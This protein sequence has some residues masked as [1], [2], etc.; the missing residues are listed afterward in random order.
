[1]TKR[2]ARALLYQRA[3][4]FMKEGIYHRARELYQNLLDSPQPLPPAVQ[5]GIERRIRQI[6]R[7]MS[8]DF[9]TV[10]K[11]HPQSP[12]PQGDGGRSNRNRQNLPQHI[13]KGSIE[14]KTTESFRCIIDRCPEEPDLLRICAGRLASDHRVSEAVEAYVKAAALFF[15]RGMIFK[16]WL[17]NLLEWRLQKAPVERLK[18]AE[19]SI[20]NTNPRSGV[21]AFVKQLS[22]DER[23]AVFSRFRLISLPAG[24]S[25]I[26]AGIGQQD[27]YIVVSG[28]LKAEGAQQRPESAKPRILYETDLFGFSG[29]DEQPSGLHPGVM[30]VT[31]VELVKISGDR[32][33]NTFRRHPNA[34]K[35]F[36]LLCHP[37]GGQR[38]LAPGMARKGE[39]YPA[40]TVM[41]LRILPLQAH[42]PPLVFKGFSHE[43]SVAGLCFIP[44]PDDIPGPPGGMKNAPTFIGRKVNAKIQAEGFSVEVQGQIARKGHVVIHGDQLPCFGIQFANISPLVRWM[45]FTFATHPSVNLPIVEHAF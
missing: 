17:C 2:V 24:K 16:G 38:S 20:R 27:L 36:Q 25:V 41:S 21:D 37:T 31:R 45:L 22:W 32:L 29:S 42:E 43:V 33:L 40:R 10:R 30:S 12:D 9:E 19:K 34:E 28:I 13:P 44:E 23:L 4:A 8:A 15:S 39:R 18:E 35:T 3:D 6:D 14:I 1:M 5:S 26:S 11:E 7:K